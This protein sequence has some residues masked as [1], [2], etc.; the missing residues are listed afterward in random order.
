MSVLTKQVNIAEHKTVTVLIKK[1]LVYPLVFEI[2]FSRSKGAYSVNI[3]E[4]GLDPHQTL[5]TIKK[6]VPKHYSA[7]ELMILFEAIPEL[8]RRFQKNNNLIKIQEY[9]E[10][11]IL[12]NRIINIVNPVIV[13]NTDSYDSKQ[14]H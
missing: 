7:D 2:P 4:S 14:N 9:C 13:F 6:L 1:G 12:A 11:R 5:A 10:H 3:D 8:V